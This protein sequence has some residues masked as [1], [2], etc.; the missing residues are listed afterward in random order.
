MKLLTEQELLKISRKVTKSKGVYFLIDGNDI[1]YVGKSNNIVS[2]IGE[3]LHE[4]TKNFNRYYTHPNLNNSTYIMEELYIRLFRPKYNIEYNQNNSVKIIND[5]T[6]RMHSI[7]SHKKILRL[8]AELTKLVYNKK[9]SL[10]MMRNVISKYKIKIPLK[11]KENIIARSKNIKTQIGVYFLI[12]SGKI[13]Y[14]GQTTN[15]AYRLGTH[16]NSNKTFDRYSFI[17][18]N[19]GELLEVEKR[20]IKK[21]KPKYNIIHN[22]THWHI[23]L[24]HAIMLYQRN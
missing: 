11:R 12:S 16:L 21:M 8:R 14:V 7:L 2:R 6:N 13:V 20:Y 4:K 17:N 15:L 18:I 3:H 22:N 1:V 5:L 23:K 9:L 24:F 19:E 10:D